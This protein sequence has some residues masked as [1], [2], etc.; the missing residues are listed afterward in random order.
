MTYG[1]PVEMI[2]YI[3]S[4]YDISSTEAKK[5]VEITL[6][7]IMNFIRQGKAVKIKGF[8]AFDIKKYEERNYVNPRTKELIRKESLFHPCFRPSK[9]LRSEINALVV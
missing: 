8:G 7:T 4:N 2:K 9:K 3:E 5:S 1:I 6:N